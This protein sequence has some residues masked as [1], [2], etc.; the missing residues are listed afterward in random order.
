[1]QDSSNLW[2]LLAQCI[3]RKKAR[4]LNIAHFMKHTVLYD[5]PPC[6]LAKNYRWFGGTWYPHLHSNRIDTA[7]PAETSEGFHQTKRL[8]TP[9]VWFSQSAPTDPHTPHA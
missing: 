2:I 5:V 9:E 3:K 4:H 6:S 7:G 8:R 1:M